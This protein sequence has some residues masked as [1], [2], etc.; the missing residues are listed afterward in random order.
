MKKIILS[1]L[2]TRHTHSALALGYLKAY[3]EQFNNSPALKIVEYDLNQTNETI[4]ASLISEK[5]EI[6]AFSVYIWSVDRIL[7]IADA[8]KTA[9][10]ETLIILGGPEVSYN[11]EEL[12]ILNPSIDYIIRG[13]GEVTFNELIT[14]ILRGNQKTPV[15]GV[16][17]RTESGITAY[18]DRPL[19]ANLDDIPCPI[20]TGAYVPKHSFIF[21]EAS[22]GC[23]SRCAYCLSS[24]QGPVRNHS[25]ARVKADLD[26]FFESN[27]SQVRFA[28]RTF[29][30][31]PAR[32]TE[33]IEYILKH[34]HKNINFH[35][36]IQA[37]F[38]S[39]DIIEL[40]SK[41]PDGMFHLEIGV[42]STN[43]R[44]LDAVNRSYDLNVLRE[45]VSL[46]R[47]KT[48]CHLHLDV[49]GGL[50]HDTFKHFCK[51]FDDVYNLKPHDIQVSLVKVLRGTPLE[52][53]L[54]NK[55]FFAMNRP[56]YTI[57][58]TNWLSPEEA[59]LIQDIGK[60]TEGIVNSLRYNL[61]IET[62]TKSVFN[63]SSSALLIE[64][65]KFWRKE[66][67]QFFNFTPEN[68]AKNLTNFVCALAL[69]I[70][71][72]KRITSLI[73]HELRMC[74]KIQ[75]PDLFVGIN[76]GEK[77]KKYEYKLS[78]GIRGYWYEQHP[79]DIQKEGLAIVAYK[80]ERDLSAV[81][82]IEVL[83]L[84]DAELFVL[85]MI[86]NRTSLDRAAE[87][88]NKYR[89]G[90]PLPEIEKV[91]EKMIEKELIYLSNNH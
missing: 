50:E 82:S 23:P 31:D 71:L 59:M 28:D 73:T 51:S 62:L 18:D 22:R 70:S 8:I 72:Q 27:L 44:A 69:P 13:E 87:L 75:G 48:A 74:Q 85:I 47:N 79:T 83:N 9:F 68:T 19:I 58:R 40:L 37:D 35:F 38:L 32:A 15:Q 7:T 26:A 89:P 61:S 2:N 55:T 56:P 6:L 88:W 49:L 1:A 43:P 30:C 46:L 67:I 17:A 34:N 76:F 90:W 20:R 29:N 5:P 57:L 52:K 11:S 54:S 10:P 4:I 84:S 21:Y 36:E 41:G 16:T 53:K 64:M 12:M 42:Q 81:P 14:Q 60:L 45:K 33:I 24:V 63:D 91:I 77:Q 86:Q 78:A 39:D 66:R 25:M 80:F 65:V 3:Y